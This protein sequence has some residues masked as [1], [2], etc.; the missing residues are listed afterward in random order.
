MVLYPDVQRKAQEEIDHVLGGCFLPKTKDL[1]NL[2]YLQAIF[3]EVIRWHTVAC[4][5]MFDT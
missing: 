5:S 4:I 3:K 1:E 2:P